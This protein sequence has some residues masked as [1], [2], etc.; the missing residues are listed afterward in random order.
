MTN[1]EILNIYKEG[2]KDSHISGLR[3]LFNAGYYLG[4]GFT[5]TTSGHDY[6]VTASKPVAVVKSQ[7]R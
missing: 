3:S 6:S 2:C 1:E 4:K 5:P 7:K